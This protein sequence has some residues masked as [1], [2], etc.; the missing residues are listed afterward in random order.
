MENNHPLILVFYLDAEMMQ[1]RE[2]IQPFAESVNYMIEQKNANMMA[3]FLPTTGEERLECINPV[4]LSEPDME[5][6]QQMIKDI[7][8]QFSVGIDLDVK[9]EEIELENKP[10][11]CGGNCKCESNE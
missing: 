3:F 2:I 10:C 9:D 1:N 6:V 5:K 11:E 4:T 7:Q 8:E